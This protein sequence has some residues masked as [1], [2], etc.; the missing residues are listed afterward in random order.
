MLKKGMES[1]RLRE[2]FHHQNSLRQDLAARHRPLQQVSF[3]QLAG[4]GVVEVLVVAVAEA[5]IA[6]AL[7]IIFYN[8]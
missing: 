7:D 2:H 1:F 4:A 8:K 5:L 6:V 3:W